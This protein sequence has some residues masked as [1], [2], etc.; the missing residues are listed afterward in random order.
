MAVASVALPEGSAVRQYERHRGRWSAHN[1]ASGRSEV[2]QRD[3]EDVISLRSN[4]RDGVTFSTESCHKGF[5]C[6]V[7]L[8]QAERLRPAVDRDHYSTCSRE[9]RLLSFRSSQIQQS[10]G[11]NRCSLGRSGAV[12][13]SAFEILIFIHVQQRRPA[14]CLRNSNLRDISRVNPA[15][16]VTPQDSLDS[17]SFAELL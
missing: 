12:R 10:K 15:L 6:W 4:E 11:R 17:D 16:I 7:S 14:R 13:Y 3:R 9:I 8:E 2:R 1:N 5:H